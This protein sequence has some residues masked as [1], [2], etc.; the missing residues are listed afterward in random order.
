MVQGVSTLYPNSCRAGYYTSGPFH[1]ASA[2][3]GIVRVKSLCIGG[4]F[5]HLDSG[6]I[7]HL[8]CGELLPAALFQYNNILVSFPDWGR[9]S[10]AN[11]YWGYNYQV[12]GAS[13]FRPLCELG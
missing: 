7:R 8:W 4:Y 1:V 13:L 6:G 5:L 2:D 9:F 11:Y 3:G 10:L 12:D